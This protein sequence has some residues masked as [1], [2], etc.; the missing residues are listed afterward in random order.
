MGYVA[1]ADGVYAKAER[2]ECIEVQGELDSH[3]PLKKGKLALLC[4]LC[5]YNMCLCVR[6]RDSKYTLTE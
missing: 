3:I 5:V 6:E 1:P 2:S 4:L